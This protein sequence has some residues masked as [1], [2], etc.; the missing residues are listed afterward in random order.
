MVEREILP[1]PHCG[2][3]CELSFDRVGE[4]VECASC[5]LCGPRIEF[6]EGVEDNSANTAKA[7]AAWNAL[8]PEPWIEIKPGDAAT[9]PTRGNE[10]VSVDIVVKGVVYELYLFRW[11]HLTDQ[12]AQRTGERRPVFRP[13]QAGE[14]YETEVSHYRIHRAP[15]GPR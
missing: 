10:T 5:C 1:C 6:E 4:F 2:E 7:V 8:C 3:A 12:W 13:S 9:Y 14:W 11:N 15:K